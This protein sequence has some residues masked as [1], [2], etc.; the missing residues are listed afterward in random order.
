MYRLPWL[1]ELPRYRLEQSAP[2]RYRIRQQ[3]DIHAL[4]TLEA[5]AFTLA[6]VERNDRSFEGLLA[7][8]DWVIDQQISHMGDRVYQSNYLIQE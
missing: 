6:T 4:S 2:S 1:A 8:M 3:P 5:I 7:T